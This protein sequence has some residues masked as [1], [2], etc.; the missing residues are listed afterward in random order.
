MNFHL[1]SALSS[2]KRFPFQALAAIF[3]LTVT[4]F[5]G[6]VLAILIYSSNQTLSFFETRPQIIAFLKTNATSE[7]ISALQHKLV[8]DTRIKEIRYVSKEE[9][10]A[11]Y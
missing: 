4:F 6:T 5:V 3:I 8:A 10:L 7:T 1:K 11:I 9:A 2:L